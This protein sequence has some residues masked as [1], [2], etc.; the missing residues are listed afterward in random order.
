M[1]LESTESVETTGATSEPD[2]SAKRSRGRPRKKPRTE[3]GDTRRPIA[4]LPAE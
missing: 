3:H 4:A 1:S 2:A